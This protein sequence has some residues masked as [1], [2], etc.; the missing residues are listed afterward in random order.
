MPLFSRPDG[1]PVKGESLVRRIMPYLMRGRNEA[2]CLHE[3]TCDLTRTLPWLAEYNARTGRKANLFHLFLFAFS[4]ALHQRPGLNR[5][6]S[7]GRIYQRD[8]VFLS[9]AA[10]R[11]FADHAPIVT[12][13]AEFPQQMTFAE[14]IE[15]VSGAVGGVRAGK[16]G[17]AVDTELKLVFLLPGFIIG[18]IMALLRWLDRV[19]LMP[20][21][22]IRSDPLFAS[23]FIANLG[24]IGIDNTYHHLFEYGNVSLFAALGRIDKK[25]L[26]A[27]GKPVVRDAISIRWSFDERINDGFYCAS[28]LNIA[29]EILEDPA[30]HVEALAL[31]PAAG[32]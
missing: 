17:G 30:R 10:K 16:G 18:M 27:D 20:S 19:N 4:R 14:C 21:G 22:M 13:K 23:G 3:A 7:G 11:E 31:A 32:A 9:F 26:V 24:S 2:I 25:V 8:K 28:S 1:K 12:I 5:F 6:I 29:K 15:R